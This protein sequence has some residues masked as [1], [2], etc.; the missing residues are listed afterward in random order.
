MVHASMRKVGGRAED[1]VAALQAAVTERGRLLM[2]LCGEEGRP[3]DAESRAWGELGVL[4]E[5]FR[6]TPG[7]VANA[8]P[9]ARFGAWGADAAALV[10]DPPQD[11]YYGPGSPL[12]RLVQAGGKVLRLGADR[13]TLTLFH[14]AEYVAR[15]AD[16]RRVA[17][18]VL[19]AGD[20]EARLL[21]IRCLDDSEGIADWPGED[22]F[23][24][25]LT[26][27][28]AAGRAHTGPVGGCAAELLDA[29]DAV[30]YMVGWLERT[31]AG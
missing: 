10:D 1:L 19:V 13:D 23:A 3:F 5:V 4:S 11:D 17:H 29:R 25:V 6:R 22:Y 27:Y 2:L 30:A 26:A 16:K 7:V 24:H 12:E 15:V 18:E 31:F 20:P 14:Y 9:I 8:H 21:T 28:L